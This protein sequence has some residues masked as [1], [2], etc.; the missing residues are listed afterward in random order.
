[1]TMSY[2]LTKSGVQRLADGA[3]VPNDTANTDWQEYQKWLAGGN[4]PEPADPDPIPQPPKDM[5]DW[6]NNL[7][8]ARKGLF[9]AEISKL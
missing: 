9:K 3:W 2:K 5:L 1:M 6:F 7:S 8:P 4:T